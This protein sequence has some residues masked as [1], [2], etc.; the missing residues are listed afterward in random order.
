M[1]IWNDYTKTIPKHTGRYLTGVLLDGVINVSFSNFRSGYFSYNDSNI[2]VW[3][4]VPDIPDI[5]WCI[6]KP[7]VDG[8][9][10][11]YRVD[12][13]KYHYENFIG[14]SWECNNSSITKWVDIPTPDIGDLR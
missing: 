2:L 4:S 9:Y 6:N 11:V 1:I 14:G 8:L 10:V 12:C 3:L 7:T 13:N 5:E